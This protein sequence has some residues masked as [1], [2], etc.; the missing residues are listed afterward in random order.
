MRVVGR[1]VSFDWLHV[2]CTVL[3]CSN[4]IRRNYPQQGVYAAKRS[5]SWVSTPSVEP[6]PL[7]AL[8]RPPHDTLKWWRHVSRP[9]KMPTKFSNGTCDA[10]RLDIFG[11][12]GRSSWTIAV[13]DDDVMGRQT[14]QGS[15]T[16]E[17]PFNFGI[18]QN[19]EF[20]LGKHI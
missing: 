17:A 7:T 16:P 19:D 11:E 1:E 12:I 3:T 10:Y 2:L 9:C 8:P 14:R 20:K 15:I 13:D 5:A 4:A 6:S 18:R